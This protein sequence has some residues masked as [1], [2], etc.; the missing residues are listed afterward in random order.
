V[1]DRLVGFGLQE[2]VSYSLID[3]DWLVRLSADGV[4]ISAEPIRVQNATSTAQSAAR[5]TLRSS[6]FDT[7]ARNLKHRD[8]FGI[9]E[10]APVYLQR[11][12]DLPEERWTI[13]FLL[14][15]K[16]EQQTWLTRP[17]DWD[18]YDVR[19][20]VVALHRA[21]GVGSRG[22][23]STGVAGL[24]PGRSAQITV[25][26]RP[27]VVYGQVDPRVAER[28]ELPE[29]TFIAEIDLQILLEDLE[30]PKAV[31]PPRFPPALR[32]VAFVVDESVPY[33]SVASEV[34]GA[35]KDVLESVTL[36]DLYRGPQVGEGK[37]SFALRLVL[38]SA[39]GT[40]T[41]ADVDKVL[42]RI[43]GRVLH[44]LGGVLRG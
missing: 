1:R 6:L 18:V 23:R 4:P 17:R 14:T 8:G 2:T 34:R 7:A 41:E 10:I 32:D 12:G 5:P 33:G 26:G 21:L 9:F 16:A 3:P 20:L 44:K 27:A 24:H 42:R 43:E 30:A 25:D 36:L 13:A 31:I 38:R 11:P 39:T 35:A 28:W 15:G 37:K 19:G 29:A 22:E 40:L